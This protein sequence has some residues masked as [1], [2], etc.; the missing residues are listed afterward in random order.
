MYSLGGSRFSHN[1]VEYKC[2]SHS[3]KL[4]I[5]QNAGFTLIS[6]GVM[7]PP[8]KGFKGTIKIFIHIQNQPY[9]ISTSKIV[10]HLESIPPKIPVINDHNYILVWVS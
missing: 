5:V 7:D 6:T 4:R 8:N 2:R 3:P 1:S 9:R 10:P